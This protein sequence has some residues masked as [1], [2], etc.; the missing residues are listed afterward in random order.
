MKIC[1]VTR[2]FDL[3]NGGIGQCSIA[4]RDGLRKRG[5]EV[6][7]ISDDGDYKNHN[8]FKYALIHLSKAIPKDCDVY[9]AMTP[10]ESIYMP[11]DKTLVTIHDLITSV[12]ANTLKSHDGSGLRGRLNNK[13][14]QCFFSMAV[15]HALKARYIT[16]PSKLTARELVENTG[17]NPAKIQVIQHGI[18]DGLEPRPKTDDIYRVGTLSILHSRK[19]IEMLIH[20]FLEANVDGELVI[21]GTGP[22]EVKIKAAAE[23]DPRIRF[24]GFIPPEAVC[25]F[26][27]SLDLFVYPS[28]VEG[29]GLPPVE[30]MACGKLVVVMEDALIPEEIKRRCIVTKDL[31]GTIKINSM[32]VRRKGHLSITALSHTAFANSHTWDSAVDRY[33]QLYEQ[34]ANKPFKEVKPQES[35][36]ERIT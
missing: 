22:D 18:I 31:V 8:Y 7:C 2:Y 21:A 5:H 12:H 27:N 3:T 13:L 20:V 19:R 28:P 34:I 30:A 36:L 32:F 4:I 23:G 24:L 16:C 17:V 25:D 1:L 11:K 33:I 14:G 9:H 26:Y 35:L 6:V 10:M 15:N 29:Y